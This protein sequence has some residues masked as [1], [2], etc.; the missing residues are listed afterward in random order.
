MQTMFEK[1]W[2]RHTIHVEPSGD[3]LLYVDRCLIHEST[4]DTKLTANAQRKSQSDSRILLSDP[5][6][7]FP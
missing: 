2:D 1:I 6:K 4:P 5:R 7:G 3:T